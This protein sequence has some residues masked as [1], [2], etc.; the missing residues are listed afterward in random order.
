MLPRLE[1]LERPFVVEAVGEGNVDACD[2]R[3]GEEVVVGVFDF[4]D[5]V[6]PGVGFCFGFISGCNGLDYDFWMEAG[7][8][9]ESVGPGGKCLEWR[10]N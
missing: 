6:L 8:V 7:G 2:G 4:W 5:A 1:G 10:M 3:V 9:D